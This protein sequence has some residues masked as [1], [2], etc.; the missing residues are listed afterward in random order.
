MQHS[1]D[2]SIR[3]AWKTPSR[4][5]LA[6]RL[7]RRWQLR[8]K[9]IAIVLLVATLSLALA[10][11]AFGLYQAHANRRSMVDSQ[12]AVAEVI[13]MNAKAALEFDNVADAT[14]MLAQLEKLSSVEA[15]VIY[16]ALHKPFATYLRK[17][18]KGEF[19]PPEA[20]VIGFQFTDDSLNTGL[21]I[22]RG[23][24]A[25]G[26]LYVQ[27]D[28]EELRADQRALTSIAAVVYVSSLL[29]AYLLSNRLQRVI[30]SPIQD[31]EETAREIADS[32]NFALRVPAHGDDEIGK[33]VSGFNHMLEEIQKQD[34]ALQHAQLNLE[35]MVSERTEALLSEIEDHQTARWELHE[36]KLDAEATNTQLAQRNKDLQEAMQQAR[37]MAVAAEAA[38][39][40][41]S[42][43]L[44]TMSHEIRTPMNGVIGMSTLLM[45]TRL[46]PEQSR[47]SEAIKSSAEGLLTII[48]D[49]LDFSKIEADRMEFFDEEIDLLKLV[50]TPVG[51]LTEQALSKGI[52]LVSYV[53]SR[54]PLLRGDGGKIRQVFTNLLGNS[55]KFTESGEVCVEAT[56]VE[57]Q[58]DRLLIRCQVSDTGIGVP[59]DLQER[60]FEPFTQADSS[61]TR[62]FGGTGLG[63]AIC[64]RLVERMGGEIQ[65][66]SIPGKGST[67]SFTLNLAK[68]ERDSFISQNERALLE[69]RR[70]LV[71]CD[72]S[73][74]ARSMSR[75]LEDW[76]MEVTLAEC[77]QVALANLLGA[78]AKTAYDFLVLDLPNPYQSIELLR[79]YQ[80][81]PEFQ[82]LRLVTLNSTGTAALVSPRMREHR[83][84]RSLNKPIRQSVLYDTMIAMVQESVPAGGQVD[85]QSTS[86]ETT[87][88]KRALVVSSSA[89]LDAVLRETLAQLGIRT[90]MAR[91]DTIG[92]VSPL[93]SD[94]IDIVFI[95]YDQHETGF[96]EMVGQLRL[97]F[98]EA[99]IVGVRGNKDECLGAGGDLHLS[100]PITKQAVQSLLG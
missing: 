58:G 25:L 12:L 22:Y 14:A 3:P 10:C 40:A 24:R 38:S 2:S 60:L 43:F 94:P 13:A 61:T 63:L 76:G 15:A 82:G 36:A 57:D 48:N 49:V 86:Q 35:K 54:I 8:E 4:S 85:A 98:P 81:N 7:W 70:V 67:F 51:L 53:D 45:G 75:C 32:R 84:V 50:E 80:R 46:S 55:M 33:L 47:F 5:F 96:P 20:T 100:A 87:C 56:L 62:K 44:A 95:Q 99:R 65:V 97:R 42:R 79:E 16:D 74:L 6:S 78:D 29:L 9:L 1:D 83:V 34:Q 92:L 88:A 11:V 72:S 71:K 18:M 93:G 68:A 31:L 17:D 30:S 23:G 91:P 66:R 27:S 59:P 89:V 64:K 19:S 39:L 73:S 28:L 41:K 52:E 77:G 37:N 21:T 69:S 90:H 26:M